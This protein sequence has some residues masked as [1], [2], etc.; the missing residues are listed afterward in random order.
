MPADLLREGAAV[1]GA[2]A[3]AFPYLVEGRRLWMVVMKT[4]TMK[5]HTR[6]DL[7]TSSLIWEYW[8][9][10]GDTGHAS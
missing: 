5:A 3:E 6:L 7:K 9:R 1:G 8:K 4:S 2:S 10:R